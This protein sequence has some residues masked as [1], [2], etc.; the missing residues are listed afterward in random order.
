M[1]KSNLSYF[2]AR[3]GMEFGEEQMKMIHGKFYC[4]TC[5][6]ESAFKFK[7]DAD[8]NSGISNHIRF[9]KLRRNDYERD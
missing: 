9:P 8:N 2:C 7:G 4:K 1:L 6:Q 3:C 5:R